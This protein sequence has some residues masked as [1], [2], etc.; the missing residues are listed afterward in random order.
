MR[1]D[2]WSLRDTM[3]QIRLCRQEHLWFICTFGSAPS[4]GPVLWKLLWISRTDRNQRARDRVLSVFFKSGNRG[5][6]S[7]FAQITGVDFSRSS[8]RIT[9]VDG[10]KG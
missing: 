1:S 6:K 9:H 4:A 7:S 3:R 8:A 10:R 5:K 2:I